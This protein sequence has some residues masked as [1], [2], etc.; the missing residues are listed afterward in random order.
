[1]SWEGAEKKGGWTRREWV[2]LGMAAGTVGTL[3]ALTASSVG[4]LLPPPIRRDGEIRD[5]IYYTKFPT[6]QWWNS[7]AGRAMRV[8]DFDTEWLGAT[9]VWRG[10]F[11]DDRL[12]PGTGF[13]VL[14]VRV[15]RDDTNFRKPADQELPVPLPEG[16]SLYYDD[17]DRDV[18]IVVMFDRCVHLCCPPGWHVVTDPPPDYNYVAPAPSYQV[19]GQDPVYCVCHGSQYEP[20]RLVVNV[21]EKSGARYVGAERVHGPANRALAIVPVRAQAD[22]LVGGMAD[23][24]WYLYCA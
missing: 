20:M 2:R 10:L 18:R 16:F 14:V 5:Q 6:P 21:H 22:V 19:Y 12:V 9:G 7:K 1:M 13:P 8:P 23:P 11:A 17:E 15:K 4:Q 3:G 24:R